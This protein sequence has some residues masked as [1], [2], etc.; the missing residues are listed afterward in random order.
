MALIGHTAASM[1]IFLDIPI[2]LRGLS[3]TM[4]G[5]V[6]PEMC[7]S[8]KLLEEIFRVDILD[9]TGLVD[10]YYHDWWNFGKEEHPVVDQEKAFD[11]H[12]AKVL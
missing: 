2:F 1:N 9:P 4:K 11:W 7:I 3:Q 8:T 6:G 5:R 12:I 10:E